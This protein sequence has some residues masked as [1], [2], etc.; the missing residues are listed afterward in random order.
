ME[1][2]QR[3]MMPIP[4]PSARVPRQ[5]VELMRRCRA[6]DPKERPSAKELHDWLL[7]C[8]G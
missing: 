2:P 3:G 1:V 6:L 4:E 5:L 7:G 8:P